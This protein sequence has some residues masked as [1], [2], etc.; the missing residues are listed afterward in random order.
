[1]RS[2][3][4]FLSAMSIWGAVLVAPPV[5][6]ALMVT[7]DF[8]APPLVAGRMW[9]A[10]YTT[11]HVTAEA[12]YLNGTSYVNRDAAG[13]LNT[14]LMVR[15]T[16]GDR[17]FGVCSASEL[18]NS[19]CNPPGTYT[20]GGGEINE[21]GNRQGAVELIRLKIDDGWDWKTVYVSS[22]DSSEKGE[23]RW[24]NSDVLTQTSVSTAALV[25]PAFMAGGAS[26]EFAFPVTGAAAGAK[27]L[28]F[29][30]GPAGTDNDYLVWKAD[31]ER[32]PEPGTLLLLGSALGGIVAANLR[33][34]R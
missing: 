33:R 30:P 6:N 29:I 11:N 21:L 22:L 24:S 2:V 32:V 31:V 19:A 23:L 8:S 27:Y 15:N 9:V 5:A 34:P 17:G 7:A 14:F 25:V 26:V 18:G 13:A 4:I 28:Y 1:M 3:A 20:G 10:S 16:V 12:Y